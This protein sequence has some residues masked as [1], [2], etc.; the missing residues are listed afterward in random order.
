MASADQ[1][2]TFG[3]NKESLGADSKSKEKVNV[4]DAPGTA[5]Y[6]KFYKEKWDSDY[7]R[8]ALLHFI[9]EQHL[10]AECSKWLDLHFPDEFPS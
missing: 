6:Y 2:N 5:P 4:A 8:N 1:P 3:D 9:H 7:A 10:D